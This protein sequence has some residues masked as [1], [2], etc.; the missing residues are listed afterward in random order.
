MKEKGN[1]QGRGEYSKSKPSHLAELYNQRH[2]TEFDDIL[3]QIH[4][5]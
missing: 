1:I 3:R 5:Y 4:N 2:S